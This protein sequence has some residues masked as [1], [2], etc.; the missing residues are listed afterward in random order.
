MVFRDKN[1]KTSNASNEIIINELKN[2]PNYEDIHEIKDGQ[3]G[4]FN[5][6]GMG[7]LYNDINRLWGIDYVLELR[8]K[9][10]IETYYIDLKGFN[11]NPKYHTRIKEDGTVE[12]MLLQIKKEYL[13]G[14]SYDGWANNPTHLIEFMIILI[15]KNL[16]F[17][18]YDKLVDYCDMLEQQK[19]TRIISFHKRRERCIEHCIVASVDDMKNYGVIFD[20]RPINNNYN[21]LA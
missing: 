1:I 21:K 6:R 17:I 9:N 18:R 5:L 10:R 11:Y 15:G 12:T 13:D 16:Y 14:R 8:V 7:K 19:E 3:H 4:R 20:V 2:L